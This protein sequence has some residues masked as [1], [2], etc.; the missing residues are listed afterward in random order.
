[1]ARSRVLAVELQSSGGGGRVAVG[2]VVERVVA[3][4]VA[5]DAF[6]PWIDGFQLFLFPRV[7]HGLCS[8]NHLC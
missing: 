7:S 4:A 8:S 2:V 1:M 5:V 6:A 3:V